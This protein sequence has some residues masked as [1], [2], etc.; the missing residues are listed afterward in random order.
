MSTTATAALLVPNALALPFHGR[1]QLAML[2]TLACSF[3]RPQAA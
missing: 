2:A 3:G 1:E